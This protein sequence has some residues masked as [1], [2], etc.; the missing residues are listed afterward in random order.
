MSEISHGYRIKTVCEITGVARNTLLAWERRYSFI[1]PARSSNGY[2]LYSDLDVSIIRDIKGYVDRGWAVSDAV[3]QSTESFSES[4]PTSKSTQHV[5]VVGHKDLLIALLAFDREAADK[6]MSELATVPYETLMSDYFVPVLQIIGDGWASGKYSIAQEHF[7]SGFIRE[8]LVSILLRLGSGPI[9][10]PRIVCCTH[11]NDSHE[12]GLFMFA[13]RMAMRGW[14]VTWL[15]AN[16]P[17]KPLIKFLNE[18]SPEAVCISVTHPPH[19]P[20][21]IEFIKCV[22]TAIPPSIE[23]V[24]GGA[25]VNELPA[26]EGV[27]FLNGIQEF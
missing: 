17:A 25:V 14:R 8:R 22:R 16:M 15:G 9:H 13:I 4:T 18:Q 7:T 20:E 2:R 3:R 10:G 27:R 6:V 5:R 24:M 21:L 1:T 23:M 19:V 12:L 26:I 11:P